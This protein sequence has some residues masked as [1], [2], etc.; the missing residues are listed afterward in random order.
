MERIYTSFHEGHDSLELSL[1]SRTV[2]SKHEEEGYFMEKI[3]IK[4]DLFI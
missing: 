4:L 2:F 1:E 3:V